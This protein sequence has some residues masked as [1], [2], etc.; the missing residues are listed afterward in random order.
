MADGPPVGR[1]VCCSTIAGNAVIQPAGCSQVWTR[2]SSEADGFRNRP[3]LLRQP[4]WSKETDR[5]PD[6]ILQMGHASR[7]TLMGT[8]IAFPRPGH[9]SRQRGRRVT[10][11]L[12]LASVIGI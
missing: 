1:I 7:R 9:I 10:I 2:V 11:A 8:V 3:P 4:T 12:A 5:S 6:R